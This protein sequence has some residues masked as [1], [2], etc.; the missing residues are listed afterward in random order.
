MGPFDLV[1][2]S[3]IPRTTE[4]AIAMGFAVDEIDPT[5][6]A[7]GAAIHREVELFGRGKRLPF[8]SW[9]ELAVRGAVCT[10]A[11]R[12]R[13]QWL[14]LAARLPERGATL[15]ISHGGSIEPGVTVCLDK[16]A[17]G[18]WGPLM[19]CEGVRLTVRAG[20]VVSAEVL[21]V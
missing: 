18:S 10:H 11:R 7:H 2:T 13:T 16:S 3:D 21:R 19:P 6:S 9:A 20:A 14:A 12:Q 15:V 1:V 17:W 4:T 5:L 8:A